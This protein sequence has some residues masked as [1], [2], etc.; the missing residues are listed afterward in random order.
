MYRFSM[1]LALVFLASFTVAQDKVDG[2]LL[3][4]KWEPETAPNGA[5]IVMEFTK[6]N[7]LMVNAEFGGQKISMDGSYKLDGD[8][9][10]VKIKEPGGQEKSTTLKVTKL[11][12][13]EMV[14]KE[15]EQ[16]EEKLK[17]VK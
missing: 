6:D 2:K 14:T 5:K 17:R 10:E 3:V 13:D 7:K 12:A 8:K 15:G 16:K 4:G 1:A 11:T 9:L